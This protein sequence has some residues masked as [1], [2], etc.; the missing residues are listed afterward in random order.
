MLRKTGRGCL[1]VSKF[2][3]CWG[4]VFP[5]HQI[6]LGAAG[7][8]RAYVKPITYSLIGFVPKRMER[9]VS[10][11]FKDLRV[12]KGAVDL[13]LKVYRLTAGFPNSEQFGLTSQMRRASVSIAS[14]IAEGSGKAT[15]GE[16]LQFLGHAKGSLCELQ[17]QLVIA[18]ALG[19]GTKES[20]DSVDRDSADVSRLLL[21]LIKSLK[22]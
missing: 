3:S 4:P 13:T 12:W 9:F 22:A 8:V 5:L 17:T 21:G 10:T 11:S 19:F 7:H 1:R 15:K 14:N 6:S 18:G 16:F 20:I 2:P